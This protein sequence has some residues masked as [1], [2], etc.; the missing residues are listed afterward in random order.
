[1]VRK[2]INNKKIII[3]NRMMGFMSTLELCWKF[4]VELGLHLNWIQIEFGKI[5]KKRAN[6]RK[7]YLCLLGP[8]HGQPTPLAVHRAAQTCCLARSHSLASGPHASAVVCPLPRPL[9]SSIWAHCLASHSR[10][11]FASLTHAR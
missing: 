1:M 11:S 3:I 6:L 5:E 7:T 9:H 2:K 10:C 8:N 4:K